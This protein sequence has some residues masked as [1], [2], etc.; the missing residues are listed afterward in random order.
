MKHA[1]ST[2]LVVA[3]TLAAAA[4]NGELTATAA[5]SCE[6]LA[7]L[8]LPHAK[9]TLAQ[10][11]GPG[12]FRPPVPADGAAVPPAAARA[13]GSL[14]AF[15]RVTATLTP[16]SDSDIKTEIWLPASGWNGKFQ[17]VGNGGWA[18]T[19]PY[20]AIAA[21]VASGYAGA[22]TDTGHVGGNADFA[23]GHPEKLIDLG[24]RS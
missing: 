10:T 19:I 1:L 16:T 13:F 22:G 3:G 11:I 4:F 18:G 23:M 8:T 15:C 12:A 7:S 14:P 21:A 17:A 9:I 20:P 24:Y 6:S 2:A 5:P